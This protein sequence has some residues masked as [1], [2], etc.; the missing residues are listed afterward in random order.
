MSTPIEVRRAR[1]I[2]IAMIVALI[3]GGLIGYVFGEGVKDLR[4]LGDIFLRIL[5]TIIPPLIFFTIG[6]AI[7]SIV[8]LR[9]L[10]STLVLMLILYIV[11]SIV[12]TTWGIRLG[13]YSVQV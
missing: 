3:L 12:A 7:A 6:Y 8:D 2:I 1:I 9:R 4:I 13:S 10:G 5:R 11:T